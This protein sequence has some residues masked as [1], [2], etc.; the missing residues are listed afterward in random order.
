M[1]ILDRY[2]RPVSLQAL[3]TEIAAPSLTGVRQVLS[4]HPAQGMTPT[5]LA[6]LLR[7]AEVWNPAA[8]LALAE[9]MEEKDLHYRSVLQTRKLAVSGLELA[10]EAASDK[11]EDVAAADLVREALSSDGTEEFLSDVLDAIGKGFSVCEILWDVSE[12]DWRPRNIVWRDPRWFTFSEIDGTTVLLRDDT[13]WSGV[14]LAPYKFVVHTPKVKSGIPLRGGLAR[15]AAWGYLFKN[16][17]LKDWVAFAEIYGQ[18]LRVGKFDA[19]ANPDQIAIL[20]EAVSSIGTDAGAVIPDSMM[21]EFVDHV[22]KANSAQIYERLL[23]YLDKQVSKAVLGHTGSADSTP[24]KLGG[25][26]Q[27]KDVRKDI[28]VADAKQLSTTLSRDVARPLVDLNLGPRA[29]YP[30]V[31]LLIE[32]PEDLAALAGNL[33]ILVPLGLDVEESWVRDKFGIPEPAADAKLL[34]PAF[35]PQS[36]Y[37]SPPVEGD[38]PPAEPQKR[39]RSSGKGCPSCG[40]AHAQGGQEK[41]TPEAFIDRAG[42]EALPLMNALLEPVRRLVTEAQ[43]LEEIR[44]GLLALYQDMD[45]SELGELMAAAFAAADLS[46]RFEAKNAR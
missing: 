33:S 32:E 19:S 25:E 34:E 8:Y 5:S 2:G 13:K 46:G 35:F 1:A 43:S 21:I 31:R 23:D 30:R 14:P 12:G 24:G 36:S 16:Y 15:A 45:P 4:S 42:N 10:V 38:L 37:P 9:E 26:D 20:K 39:R 22:G 11:A 18:P 7:A 6:G 27:A 28:V 41:D 44:D 29:V 40:A 3:K 17:G